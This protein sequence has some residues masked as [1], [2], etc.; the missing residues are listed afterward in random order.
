MSG[1]AQKV[2]TAAAKPEQKGESV[3]DLVNSLRPQ[4]EAALPRQ[5]DVGRFLRLA[6]TELR[7]KPKL[8]ATDPRSLLGSI[9]KAA[10]LGL[11]I[12][13]RGLA[14]LVPY[15]KECTLVI[16]YQGMM[17][18]ARRDGRVTSIYA[19]VVREADEFRYQYG[20][21]PDLVHR[22]AT[23]DRGPMVYVYAVA[24]LRDTEP[25]FVVLDK[26]EVD[27]FRNRS[28]TSSSGP[29]VTDYEAM[30]C[31]TAVRRLATWLPQSPELAD[32][33]IADSRS[34]QWDAASSSVLVVDEEEQHAIEAKATETTDEGG[35]DAEA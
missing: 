7:V 27:R 24:R 35:D 31:K 10:Q 17:E 28:K 3:T 13:G 1:L 33:A 12:D 5:L 8:V 34:L 25:V 32:A 11:E 14:Y 29:W 22:P 16:G 6:L 26:A 20:L 15:G 2:T 23:G 4:M 18:L 21:H 19:H 9:M 30:A